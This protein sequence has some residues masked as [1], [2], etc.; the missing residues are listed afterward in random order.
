MMHRIRAALMDHFG[1]L[2]RLPNI[3]WLYIDIDPAG[4][5]AAHD[6]T[7]GVV[8][9]AQEVLLTRLSITDHYEKGIGLRVP[10]ASWL[11]PIML[12]RIPRSLLTGGVRALGR[13]ALVDHYSV[14]VQKLREDLKAC[15]QHQAL[16][17]A[18][19]STGL[20]IR[21]NR[22]RIYLATHLGG[23]TGGGMFIDLAYLARHVLQQLGYPP[24]QI[25]GIFW[26][27]AGEGRAEKQVPLANTYAALN[28][29]NHFSRPASRFQADYGDPE[30][31]LADEGPP[32]RRCLFLP[33]GQEEGKEPTRR[34]TELAAGFVFAN[35][36]T[37][38]GR[39]ADACREKIIDRVARPERREGREG[40]PIA[41]TPFEDS[42]RATQL[43][44]IFE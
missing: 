17:A 8:L 25:D 36:V 30:G 44:T 20:G 28:E 37:P 43:P 29:L 22:P 24:G 33:M 41:S 42:G 3:R 9:S 19:K 27:P 38:L 1:P 32:F 39:V 35:L 7:P 2:Q 40:A 13:L 11:N 21:S 18:A 4:A 23:G 16:A 5:A 12:Y 31:S 14:I 10:I 26:L 6:G 34:A 15:C